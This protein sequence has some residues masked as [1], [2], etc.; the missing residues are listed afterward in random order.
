[1]L[2]FPKQTLDFL[3]KYLQRQKKEV[4]QSIRDIEEDDPAKSPALAESSEPGTDS[5]I[6]DTHTKSEV[7]KAQLIRMNSIIKIALSKIK[8]GTYGKC[9][10]CGKQIETERLLALP[11]AQY[12]LSCSQKNIK[13]R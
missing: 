10:N 3:H 7:I 6:A 5:Y 2:N 1:M 13:K 12:C 11:S 8:I 9:D 4:D